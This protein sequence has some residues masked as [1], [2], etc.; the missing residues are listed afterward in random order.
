MSKPVSPKPLRKVA[1][2]CAY[3]QDDPSVGAI[4]RGPKLERD[5]VEAAALTDERLQVGLAERIAGCV[6][7]RRRDRSADQ[8]GRGSNTAAPSS[9]PARRSANAAFASSRG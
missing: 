3:S 7:V 2:I 5:L 9:L 1:A 8:Q 6:I 4:P